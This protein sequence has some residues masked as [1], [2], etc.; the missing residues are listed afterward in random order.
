MT[1]LNVAYVEVDGDDINGQINK[2][3]RQFK[4]IDAALLAMPNGGNIIMG[5]G[6]FK[7]P[8]TSNIKD[9]HNFYGSGM[10]IWKADKTGMLDG[11]GT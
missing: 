3:G 6:R 9:N 7:S 10:P 1:Q 5:R 8:T 2:I 4:T 11:T